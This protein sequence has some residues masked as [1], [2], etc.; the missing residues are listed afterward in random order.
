MIGKDKQISRLLPINRS[1]SRYTPLELFPEGLL[2]S[3]LLP[4]G[5]L[6]LLSVRQPP[7]LL[8]PLLDLPLPLFL[9]ALM[10]RKV[11]LLRLDLPGSS[12]PSLSSLDLRSLLTSVLNGSHSGDLTS[13]LHLLSISELGLES[14]VL[15]LPLTFESDPSL[16]LLVQLGVGFIS[17][18]LL[19]RG[20]SLSLCLGLASSETF[21]LSDK[22][23]FLGV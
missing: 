14:F 21:E 3:L 11:L 12:F 17:S 15:L 18:L 6:S 2:T 8:I 7:L 9:R 23:L 13:F 1:G 10:L 5:L 16:H 22:L 4:S 19:G 20:R